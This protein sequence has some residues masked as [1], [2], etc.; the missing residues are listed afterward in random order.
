MVSKKISYIAIVMFIFIF[1]S[2]ALC[3]EVTAPTANLEEQNV[4]AE[5]PSDV[6]EDVGEKKISSQTSPA[7]QSIKEKNG[8]MS[9][10]VKSKS[11]LL[12]LVT[13][14]G[15]AMYMIIFCSFIGTY[16][17]IERLLS[18][19]TKKII[20]PDFVETVFDKLSHAD[21]NNHPEQLQKELIRMCKE[22]NSPISRTLRAGLLVVDEGPIGIKTVID[23]AAVLEASMME[24]NLNLLG[25]AANLAPLLGFLGTVTGMIGAFES[26]VH[27]ENVSASV[28]A[29]GISQA[30]VTTAAGLFVGIPLLAMYYFI[31]GASLSLCWEER[32]NA[33]AQKKRNVVRINLNDRHDFSSS[34]IFYRYHNL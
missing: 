21:K 1:S 17:I 5:V 7:P 24:K 34:N 30:L 14:G 29:A 20:P 27:A 12:T 6:T 4:Q 23:G 19:R 22:N 16:F 8:D 26:I 13:Q 15:V 11:A 9:V 2:G 10:T 31:Q 28:V 32:G 18:V 33:A 25:L 3:Q